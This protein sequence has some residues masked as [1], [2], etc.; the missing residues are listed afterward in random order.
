MSVAPDLKREETVE[1]MPG[2]VGQL[3]EHSTKLRPT[4]TL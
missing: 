3:I 4:S 2:S 1:S